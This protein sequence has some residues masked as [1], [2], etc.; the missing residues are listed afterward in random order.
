M[1]RLSSEND[2][3]VVELTFAEIVELTRLN[4]I[5]LGSV[6]YPPNASDRPASPS[7]T[8]ASR[9]TRSD[10]ISHKALE[11]DFVAVM[12]VVTFVQ[13]GVTILTDVAAENMSAVLVVDIPAL[14]PNVT[15]S[16]AAEHDQTTSLRANQFVEETVNVSAAEQPKTAPDEMENA[17]L[18]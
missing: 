12:V 9:R 11:P 17:V 8:I 4:P 15:V 10:A 6:R 16:I 7:V 13:V 1:E 18:V 3:S 5:D 2:V 14:E